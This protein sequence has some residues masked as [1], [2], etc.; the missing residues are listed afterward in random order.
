MKLQMPSAKY[1]PR[2]EI[3]RNRSI[4]MADLENH[5]RDRDLDIANQ[6][7]VLTSPDGTRWSV[8]VDNA[9]VLS[10]TAI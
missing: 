9:G 10:A 7:L 1:D 4:E 5:K 8:T 3:E 2:A 6:R